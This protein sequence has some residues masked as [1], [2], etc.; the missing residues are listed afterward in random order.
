MLEKKGFPTKEQI[1]SCFPEKTVILNPKA[2]IECYEKIPCNPCS[3]S[4]PFNAI[5]I[6]DDINQIPV[7]DFN[8]CTGCGVCVFSCPGLA[9]KVVQTD[10]KHAKFKIP[11]EFIPYPKKNEIWN[12]ID[13][14]GE[15]IGK[16][17]IAN[18]II[19]KKQNK[20]ALVEVI[21]DDKIIYD[22]A[23]IRRQVYE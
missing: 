17:K 19:G 13:H 22:F 11:Y 14:A 18:V 2:I 15:V 7:I 10:G 23:T 8:K 20:T 21:V 1:Q 5:Y 3:T 6:G 12:A 9:I 16:A 4:C